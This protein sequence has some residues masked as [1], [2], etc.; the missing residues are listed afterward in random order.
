MFLSFMK[1]DD[2]ERSNTVDAYDLAIELYEEAIHH[3][4]TRL[5]IWKDR[6]LLKF[7]LLWRFVADSTIM[8]AN[9]RLGHARCLIYRNILSN[10]S[11]RRQKKTIV[12]LPKKN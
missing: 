4:D 10:L 7:P 1:T 6:F 11:G 8:E 9:M 5:F 12:G 2:F 3:F